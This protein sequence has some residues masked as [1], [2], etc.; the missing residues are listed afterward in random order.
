MKICIIFKKGDI[1][2]VIVDMVIQGMDIP[3]TDIPDMTTKRH[4]P[5]M[6]TKSHV[7]L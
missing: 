1:L 2:V 6:G 4:I 3:G 5:D 7:A